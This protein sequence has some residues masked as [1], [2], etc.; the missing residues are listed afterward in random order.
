MQAAMLCGKRDGI[1]ELE[2]I[3]CLTWTEMIALADVLIGIVWTDLTLAEQEE[4]FLSYTSDPRVRPRAEDAVYDCR[5][6]SL[7][8]LAWLTEGWPESPGARVGQ[9]MLIR[10]LTADRNRLCRHL[11]PSSADPWSVGPGPTTLSPRFESGCG[12]WPVL[13]DTRLKPRLHAVRLGD[14]VPEVVIKVISPGSN[15]LEAIQMHFEDLQNGKHR[16]LEMD[17]FS[18]PVVGKRAARAL[19]D[20]WDLDLDDLYWR[21][22]YLVPRRRKTPKLVHKILFSMPAGTPPDKLLA[23]VRNFAQQQFADQHRYALALHTDEPHPHVHMVLKAMT[24]GWKHH[25]NIRKPALREWRKAF[26]RHLCALGVP[27]KATRGTAR[28]K[29]KTKLPGIYRPLSGRS[30][31]GSRNVEKPARQVGCTR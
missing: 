6:A 4:I 8:F 18:T 14:G 28:R 12:S 9:S 30:R 13:L 15:T 16:A 3:G 29:T 11:R 19:S 21:Q 23:A 31:L 10:W 27:A 1:T 17:S 20:D 22:P 26:A 5:H 7:Q 2:G 24:E 25:L